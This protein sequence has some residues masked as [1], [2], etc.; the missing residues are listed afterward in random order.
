MLYASKSTCYSKVYYMNYLGVTST[1]DK[2]RKLTKF[3]SIAL[4]CLQ[5]T[6]FWMDL[7]TS[8]INQTIYF[9]CTE[10]QRRVGG[11]L[12]SILQAYAISLCLNSKQRG[13]SPVQTTSHIIR[14]IQCRAWTP[15]GCRIYWSGHNIL[16]KWIHGFKFRAG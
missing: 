5:H 11:H 14:W 15:N 10:P 2:G 13:T 9:F 6:T 1:E 3:R 7:W 12:D 8:F 4:N 16:I